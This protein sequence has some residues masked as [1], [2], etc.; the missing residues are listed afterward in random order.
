MANAT[1]NLVRH[2][3]GSEG[4][5]FDMPIAAS[6]HIY[7][8]TLIS[9]KTTGGY[10]VPYSTAS[11]DVCIGVSQHEADNSAGADGALRLRVES[12]RTYL[13][14]NG[15]GGDA[16]AD[17]DKI[18][19]LVYATDDHTVAKTSS[20]ETRA[21]VGFYMGFDTDSGLVRV[22]VDPTMA[23]IVYAL[24]TIAD[25]PATVEALRTEIVTAFG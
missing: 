17:T 22:H 13:F 10:C 7:E 25:A 2:S 12:R 15:A 1:S 19:A 24:Q 14:A 3:V 21:P 9:Q 16:F 11:S 5:I 23:R 20:T 6:T 4:V 8:G 18:G